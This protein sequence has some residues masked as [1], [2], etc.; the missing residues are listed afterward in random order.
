MAEELLER[1]SFILKHFSKA[2]LISP[3]NDIYTAALLRGGGVDSIEALSPPVG[4]QLSLTENHYDAIFNI[5]D[6]QCVNDVP[7][8]LAQMARALKPDGILMVAFFA[9]DTLSELRQSWLHAESEV[10][11]G[12]SPRVAPMIGVRELGGLMQR[13]KLAQP[14]ADMENLTLRY[15]DVFALMREIKSFGYA[16]PLEGRSAKPVSKRMLSAMAEHYHNN[17]ADKDGRIRA[18][19]DIAWATAWSPHESQ[20]QPLKPGSAKMN[21]ADALK[22]QS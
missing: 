10:S 7:G 1:L 18:T 16:N 15:A 8:Q 3:A 12:A 11:G 6:L 22:S 2:L 17:F 20:Q 13:A 21:L 4:D 19:I 14:I 9:G 5:L